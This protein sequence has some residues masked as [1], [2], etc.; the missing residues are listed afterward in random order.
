M[1]ATLRATLWVSE[2][3]ERGAGMPRERGINISPKLETAGDRAALACGATFPTC[4]LGPSAWERIA[5]SCPAILGWAHIQ[6][7]FILFRP[8]VSNRRSGTS[9]VTVGV[10]V[11][12]SRCFSGFIAF[13]SMPQL[14]EKIKLFFV[15]APLY[16]FHHVKGPVLKIA[17]LPD[18]VLKVREVFVCYCHQNPGAFSNS[19]PPRCRRAL[20]PCLRQMLE[21]R[22]GR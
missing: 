21:T 18:A 3:E 20:S 17:F 14:A 8:C 10:I 5:T 13:S 4:P 22:V 11:V 15:L 12:T 7:H 9:V 16:T 2:E 1:L 6:E 19:C